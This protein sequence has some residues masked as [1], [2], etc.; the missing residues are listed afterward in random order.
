MRERVLELFARAHLARKERV[1]PALAERVQDPEAE[2]VDEADLGERV[3]LGEVVER[4]EIDEVQV[5]E[6]VD[7]RPARREIA[8][9][10]GPGFVHLDLVEEAPVDRAK[11]GIRYV[12]LR[13]LALGHPGP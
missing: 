13:E 1:H 3:A 11:R 10:G 5:P 4:Q 8:H 7:H 9:R 12:G 2:V 6:H